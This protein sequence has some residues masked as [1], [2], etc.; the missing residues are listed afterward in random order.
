MVDLCCN[1]TS[2]AHN[3][4]HCCCKNTIQVGGDQTQD[5]TGT[6]C[7][8]FDRDSAARNAMESPQMQLSVDCDATNCVYNENRM[9]RAEHIDI[10][11]GSA[12]D[13]D[14]TIC[15]TFRTR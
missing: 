13:A 2:C 12:S 3:T 7:A 5:K 8:S 1:V 6:C 11:G 14:G 4:D 10:S 15:A 9:C